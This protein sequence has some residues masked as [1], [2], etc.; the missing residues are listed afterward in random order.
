MIRKS[1]AWVLMAGLL[2]GLAPGITVDAFAKDIRWGTSRVG[3]TGNRTVT[4]LVQVLNKAVPDYNFSVQPTSGAILTVKGYAIGEFEGYYGS[5][6]AFYE[7]ANNIRRFEGFREKMEREPVQSFWTFTIEMGIGIHAR[8]I[9]RITKWGDLHGMRVFTGPRPWDTR[10]QVER[11]F[12]V[13]GIEHDYLEVGIK[14]AGSL[15]EQG[16]FAALGVYTNAEAST[17][18]W[19]QEASLQT[20]WAALS[21]DAGELEKLAAAGFKVVEVDTA[22]FGK[23]KTHVAK[24]AM[25][26]F[27]YGL[28][29]GMDVSGGGHVPDPA[30]GRGE[31]G[32]ACHGRQGVQADSGGHGPHAAARRGGGGRPRARA[33]RPR[34]VHAR[35]GRV[36]RE[37]GFAYRSVDLPAAG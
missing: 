32:R 6:I 24:A 15:L 12:T 16:R 22:A 1:V 36:G 30:G 13:L 28:H 3:S 37:V 18:G 9:G 19:I 17:A 4:N 11:A 7:L 23:K 21:P 27:Y 25:L 8:D 33:P 26:P 10:A 34:E 2:S 5:D 35:A 20:D 14:E 31:R 29:L